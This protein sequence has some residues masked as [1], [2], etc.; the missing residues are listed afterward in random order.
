MSSSSSSCKSVFLRG[1]PTFDWRGFLKRKRDEPIIPIAPFDLDLKMGAHSIPVVPCAIEDHFISTVSDLASHLRTRRRQQYPHTMDEEFYRNDSECTSEQ[2]LQELTLGWPPNSGECF[3]DSEHHHTLPPEEKRIATLNNLIF[4]WWG[5]IVSVFIDLEPNTCFVS[6][7]GVPLYFQWVDQCNHIYGLTFSKVL[8]PECMP[9]KYT[10]DNQVE[11]SPFVCSSLR[12]ALGRQFQV[13]RDKICKQSV[14]IYPWRITENTLHSLLHTAPAL[15]GD[16]TVKD[17][18]GFLPLHDFAIHHA[19]EK[20]SGVKDADRSFTL[21]Q[22]GWWRSQQVKALYDNLQ[23]L[24][25]D[26]MTYILCPY[27]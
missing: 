26:I 1:D 11:F 25:S 24:S 3:Y 21:D 13:L 2:L 16:A 6:C 9:I 10:K 14:K 5:R 20:Y 8:V 22:K 15:K 18:L 4:T 7:D 23:F 19:W 27:I 17:I 12:E